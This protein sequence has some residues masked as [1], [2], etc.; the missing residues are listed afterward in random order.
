MAPRRLSGLQKQ[1]LSL[2]RAALRV[3]AQKPPGQRKDLAAHA[4]ASIES[5]RGV[6]PKN[7]QLIEHLIRKG[8]R[9]LAL[10]EDA[11][12]TAFRL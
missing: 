3:A 5:H 9:Q 8:R 7:Y 10:L 12:V 4:R 1:A 6:S 2:Y 11:S